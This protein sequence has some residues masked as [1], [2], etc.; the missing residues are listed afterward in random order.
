MVSVF[1]SGQHR[2]GTYGREFAKSSIVLRCDRPAARQ[3][4]IELAQLAQ[5]QR[6]LQIAESIV[7]PQV[8]HLIEP[9]ANFLA[10]AVVASDAMTAEALKT[11]TSPTKI[12]SNVTVNSQL[13]TLT[14]F[15]MERISF[16]HGDTKTPNL[17]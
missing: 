16:H 13:S 14:R 8:H 6:T 11:I 5:A 9:G 17:S 4:L 15:A 1:Y 12:K 10:L 2:Q 7:V 3:P